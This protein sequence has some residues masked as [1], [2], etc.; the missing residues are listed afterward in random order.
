MLRRCAQSVRGLFHQASTHD[1]LPASASQERLRFLM[2]CG[3]L[4]TTSKAQDLARGTAGSQ[5]CA[6][7]APVR[8]RTIH[9]RFPAALRPAAAA[10]LPPRQAPT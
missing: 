5:D 8:S 1:V 4:G 2:H 10:P 6:V 9:S 7:S 3:Q